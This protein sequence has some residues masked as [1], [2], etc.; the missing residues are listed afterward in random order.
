MHFI[1]YVLFTVQ[2]ASSFVS[3]FTILFIC[4]FPR[5]HKYTVIF[6]LSLLAWML[7]FF[8]LIRLHCFVISIQ[9]LYLWRPLTFYSQ[10][11]H[12]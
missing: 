8:Y 7:H 5:S 4:V 3:F 2:Q 9:I 1:T 12:I 6:L 11:L 10:V